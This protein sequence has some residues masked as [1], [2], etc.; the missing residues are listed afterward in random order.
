MA[1]K[2]SDILACIR[3]SIASRSR[4]VIVPLYSALVRPHHKYNV[5]FW[6]PH[7][8]RDIKSLEHVQRTSIKLVRGFEHKPYEE[9][10]GSWDCLVW[11]RGGSGEML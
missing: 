7:Y 1:K 11:R 5:Q 10:L 3:N 2:A 6:G 4:E 8:N 9:W